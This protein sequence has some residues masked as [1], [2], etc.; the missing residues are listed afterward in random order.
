[1]V[2][3]ILLV[4]LRM[5]LDSRKMDRDELLKAHINMLRLF[6]KVQGNHVIFSKLK[7]APRTLV[8]VFQFEGVGNVFT[9]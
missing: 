6:H 4:K 9:I 2:Y 1:M 7:D 3:F 8:F 5:M